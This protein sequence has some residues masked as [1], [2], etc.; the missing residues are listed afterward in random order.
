M[1]IIN[2]NKLIASFMGARI[3]K[4][5]DNTEGHTFWNEDETP[6]RSGSFPDGSTSYFNYECGYNTEWNWLM[7]VIDK[8][9]SIP[10]ANLRY[11]SIK[12]HNNAVE[13]KQY[14]SYFTKTDNQY[15][16]IVES[17]SSDRFTASYNSVVD[18]I[19]WYNKHK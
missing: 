6:G 4:F 7:T 3:T 19:K 1:D 17:Y 15:D 9:E 13:H 8:I 14:V 5:P 18:I 12:F 2:N 11:Y 16:H 10:F